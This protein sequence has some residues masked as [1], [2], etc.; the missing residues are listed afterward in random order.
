ML[1]VS[2]IGYNEYNTQIHPSHGTSYKIALS[3]ATYAIE[4]ITVKPKREH[5][6]K[7]DNPAVEFVRQMIEHRDDH[8]PNEKDFWQRE[9][10]EKTTFALNN[11]DKEKQ[12]KWLYRNLIF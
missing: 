6:R 4:E 9:R 7:K 10:Y 2:A 11:F 3:T 12:K 5:Y 1:I 8:S